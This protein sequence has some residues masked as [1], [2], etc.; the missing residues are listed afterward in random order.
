MSWCIGVQGGRDGRLPAPHARLAVQH[1]A[2][3][4]GAPRAHA[5]L[6]G[7]G[8]RG[9]E[10]PHAPLGQRRRLEV[11]RPGRARQRQVPT[12]HRPPPPPTPPTLGGSEFQSCNFV[13]FNVLTSARLES[14]FFDS[15][16]INIHNKR[17]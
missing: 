5:A 13:L 15:S 11:V 1:H 16:Q 7:H 4:G 9:G 3:H 17:F 10:Q 2:R 6:P 14:I 8:A 12:A